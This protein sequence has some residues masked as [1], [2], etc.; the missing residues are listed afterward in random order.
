MN[1]ADANTK[2]E[3]T[4]AFALYCSLFILEKNVIY[5]HCFNH[6]FSFSFLIFFWT[7]LNGYFWLCA[8]RS[9]LG[10]PYGIPRKEPR[11]AVCKANTLLAILFL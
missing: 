11:S 9:F 1:I 5:F 2:M 4:I 6:F 8:Q 10:E 7:M 3:L